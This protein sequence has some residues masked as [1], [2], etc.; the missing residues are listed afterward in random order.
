MTEKTDDKQ[1]P[2]WQFQPGQSGNPKGR[3]KGA[4]NKLTEDWWADLHTAWQAHG[5]SA[6]AS[7]ATNDPGKFLTVVASV[8]PKEVTVTNLS[9]M[10]DEQ[11]ISRIANLAALVGDTIGVVAGVGGPADGAEATVRPDTIN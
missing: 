6:L 10:T 3:S 1:R 5:P 8:M 7:V 4:K 2:H 11:L 9:E